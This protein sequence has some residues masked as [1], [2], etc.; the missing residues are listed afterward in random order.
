MW[1]PNGPGESHLEMGQAHR[2]G[3]SERCYLTWHQGCGD[4]GWFQ[5]LP[6]GA[7]FGLEFEDVAHNSKVAELMGRREYHVGETH[8][9][10]MVTFTEGLGEHAS[11]LSIEA[12]FAPQP[13]PE[14]IALLKQRMHNDLRDELEL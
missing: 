9:D 11:T 12:E 2:S 7:Q 13:R 8:F 14:G 10:I 1:N 5:A 3:S 6:A 4:F